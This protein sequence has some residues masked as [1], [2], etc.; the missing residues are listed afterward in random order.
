MAYVEAKVRSWKKQLKERSGDAAVEVG[1]D[2]YRVRLRGRR[3]A[4]LKRKVIEQASE[5]ESGAAAK[6]KKD[7]GG[8]RRTCTGRKDSAG[9]KKKERRGDQ[10][11]VDRREEGDN[12]LGAGEGN[13]TPRWAWASTRPDPPAARGR[14]CES[15]VMVAR[16]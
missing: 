14:A 11:P 4:E 6:D 12:L 1:E 16:E 7:L 15:T 5:S 8:K 13:L 10:G 2:A 9:V 3:L